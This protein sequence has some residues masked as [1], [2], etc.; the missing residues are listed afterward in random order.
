MKTS[1]QRLDF[2]RG[3]YGDNWRAE[4]RWYPRA[5]EFT[6]RSVPD[7]R[8]QGC[9]YL[10]LACNTDGTTTAAVNL[11][12]EGFSDQLDRNIRHAGWYASE[13]NWSGELMRGGVWRLPC[14]NCQ[15]LFVAGY[16]DGIG[17]TYA[18]LDV[19]TFDNEKDAARRGDEMAQHAAD[20]AREH[21][22]KWREE[23]E[24]EDLRNAQRA[25]LENTQELMVAV[26]AQIAAVT[27]ALATMRTGRQTAR[28]KAHQETLHNLRVKLETKACILGKKIA[29]LTADI[30][31]HRQAA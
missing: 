3:K 1:K 25:D 29:G 10:H 9:K 8:T 7:W 15:A 23:Q 22:R 17:D 2:L 27:S 6:D 13:E 14:R 4:R 11:R 16:V 19:E 30:G 18:V 31:E 12:F 21:D 26:T 5:F 24:T 28:G 20:D